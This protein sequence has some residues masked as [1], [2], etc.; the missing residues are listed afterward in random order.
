MS[1][2]HGATVN[3]IPE[4]LRQLEVVVPDPCSSGDGMTPKPTIPLAD[5]LEDFADH[6][7]CV[8]HPHARREFVFAK[9]VGVLQR[10]QFMSTK[11]P[12]RKKKKKNKERRNR[13]FNWLPVPVF[14]D[15][16]QCCFM[17]TASSRACVYLAMI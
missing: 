2:C 6:H 9:D 8:D 1:S 3:P 5:R 14:V 12:K 7:I 11:A 13:C 4:M 16:V 10:Y 15:S 17:S